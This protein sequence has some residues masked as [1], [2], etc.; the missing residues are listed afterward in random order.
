MKRAVLLLIVAPLVAACSVPGAVSPSI[1]AVDNSPSST[2][3]TSAG[4]TSPAP[5]AAGPASAMP[6]Q[7]AGAGDAQTHLEANGTLPTLITAWKDGFAALGEDLIWTSVDGMTW[8]VAETSGL[9]GVAVDF[10]ERMDGSLL[11]FGYLEVQGPDSFRTWA[12][13]D[14]RAWAEV[15][16]LPKTFVFIDVAY[17]GR[18]YVLAGRDLSDTGGANP[19][20]LWY[21]PDA[22]TWELVRDTRT[23]MMLAAVGAGPEGFVAVGQQGWESGEPRGLVVASSD[24]T[25]WLEAPADDAALSGAGSLW[26]VAAIG[27]DWVTVPLTT[28]AEL[29]I[30][31]SANGLA[32]E[33]RSLVPVEPVD[34]GVMSSLYSDGRRLFMGITD[35]GGRTVT[36]ADLLTSEDGVS[37][38]PTGIPRPGMPNMY[39]V[40]GERMLFLVDGSVY[41]ARDD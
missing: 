30:L 10:I 1:P 11:A 5:S 27:G 18:G 7:S 40:N 23:D 28:G 22:L 31:W 29:P 38:V 12:S 39:A 9:D 41:E 25:S 8:D 19:D 13:T 21:S 14:G 4:P 16:I 34:V 35:G 20:Q 3:G 6:G 32:W 36:A 17:G 24:G 26:T 37:W 33:V 2:P 15:Q